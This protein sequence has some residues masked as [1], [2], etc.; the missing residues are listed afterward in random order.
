MPITNEALIFLLQ[1]N[2]AVIDKKAGISLRSPL[3][4]VNNAYGDEE[5]RDCFKKAGI[6]GKWFALA[7]SAGNIYTMWGVKP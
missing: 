5:I 1:M 6:V 3:K 4:A 2:S 7:G